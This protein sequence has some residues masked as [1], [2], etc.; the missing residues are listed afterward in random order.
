ML[1]VNVIHRFTLL[2]LCMLLLLLLTSS[3]LTESAILSPNFNEEFAEA[4]D[5]DSS[6]IASH[7]RQA[8]V[9]EEQMAKEKARE[10][11]EKEREAMEKRRE[12]MDAK[13]AMM[14][15]ERA[16][17]ESMDMRPM[18]GGPVQIRDSPEPSPEVSDSPEP[19][20]EESE[21]PRRDF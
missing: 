13:K 4:H 21:T 15:E 10:M 7:V 9:R 18:M 3:T 11:K 1:T 6:V 8:T 19:S 16:K 20:P 12:M 17:K 2:P 14:D 5:I